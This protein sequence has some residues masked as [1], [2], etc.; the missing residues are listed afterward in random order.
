MAS[1]SE[2]DEES[3]TKESK[4]DTLESEYSSTEDKFNKDAPFISSNTIHNQTGFISD[5]NDN[6]SST[7][8]SFSTSN[9]VSSDESE[10]NSG[11]TSNNSD[12]ETREDK[13]T[14][15]F[16]YDEDNNTFLSEII[17]HAS[18]FI[19]IDGNRMSSSSSPSLSPSSSITDIHQLVTSATTNN[20]IL[21]S[22]SPQA[23][24]TLVPPQNINNQKIEEHLIKAPPTKP[25]PLKSKRRCEECTNCLNNVNCKKCRFCQDMKKYG[26]LG[27]LRQKCIERQC[28]KLS[29][30][31]AQ[32]M[33]G[34]K[35]ERGVVIPTLMDGMSSTVPTLS[36]DSKPFYV[37]TSE[38]TP[39]ITPTSKPIKKQPIQQQKKKPKNK[40]PS[41]TT[42]KKVL[43]KRPINK[44]E[45][46]SSEEE[47]EEMSY[48]PT[49]RRPL[50]DLYE[51][52]KGTIKSSE[53]TKR[54]CLGPQC[55]YA[56]RSNSKYCSEEC[57]VELAMR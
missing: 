35:E 2:G 52:W 34:A 46:D 45:G 18:S 30:V 31:L 53:D 44:R 48:R 47:E 51:S 22:L 40:K 6:N 49:R 42:R 37:T 9:D 4:E 16:F 36:K 55:M 32:E 39:K 57:G 41:Q 38:A 20:T 3:I 29:R 12:G 56:A 21:Q 28:L 19:S 14:E 23:T 10:S 54:Q 27:R 7:H 43:K 5:N 25:H 24:P 1:N 17:D 11:D 33:G 50:S 15:G 13:E 8:S 26:G